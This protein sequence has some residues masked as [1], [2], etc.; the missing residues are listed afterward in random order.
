MSRWRTKRSWSGPP[1][2]RRSPISRSTRSSPPVS[3]DGRR[4]CPSWLWLSLG[5]RAAFAHALAEAK[6]VFIRLTLSQSHRGDGR[7]DRIEEIRQR[8]ESLDRPGPSRRDR[9]AGAS[10]LEIADEIGY[11]RVMIKASAGGGGKGMRIARFPQRGRGRFRLRG[12]IGGEILL[13]RRPCFRREI[14]RQSTACRNPGTRRQARERHLPR[15]A[16]VFD[17]APQPEG[18]DRRRHLA[19]ARCKNA[20]E[21]GRTGG[22]RSPEQCNTIPPARSNSSPA[23]T[24]VSTSSR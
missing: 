4:G 6:I 8:R 5:A 16:G 12:P 11:I 14:H 19:A 23:R 2:V 17:P 15:R 24:E 13:R 1:A 22:S 18:G 9:N 7:Q 21:N 20:Q 3:Q 10:R